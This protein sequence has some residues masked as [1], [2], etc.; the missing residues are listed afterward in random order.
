MKAGLCFQISP[1]HTAPRWRKTTCPVVLFCRANL[2]LILAFWERTTLA[3]PLGWVLGQSETWERSGSSAPECVPP[4]P[5][6]PHSPLGRSQDSRVWPK[7]KDVFLTNK[8]FCF[9]LGFGLCGFFFSI[10]CHLSNAFNKYFF[11]ILITS[12][13]GCSGYLACRIAGDRSLL[14]NPSAQ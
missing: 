13:W 11:N 3:F 1:L 14:S 9:L 4:A 5:W 2:F 12:I 10:S 8:D 6:V 7:G